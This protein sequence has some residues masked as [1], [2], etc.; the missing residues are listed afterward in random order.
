MLRYLFSLLKVVKVSGTVRHG[1]RHLLNTLLLY[2]LTVCYI[3][4][5]KTDDGNNSVVLVQVPPIDAL[6]VPQ[7]L[8]SDL[9]S[10]PNH[11]SW[12]L[13]GSEKIL[14]IILPLFRQNSG[15]KTHDL[16]LARLA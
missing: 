2:C 8:Y 12:W 14:T 1:E 15:K 11:F 6:V 4:Q 16:E 5:Q 7:F 10:D 9:L 3:F 13:S